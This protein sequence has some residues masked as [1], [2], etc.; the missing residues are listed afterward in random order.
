MA[1]TNKQTAA[2][3]VEHEL[4]E[5]GRR[6]DSMEP[7]SISTVAGKSRLSDASLDQIREYAK[8]FLKSSFDRVNKICNKLDEKDET[9]NDKCDQDSNTTA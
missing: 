2:R 4:T 6:L 5:V 1:L 9:D 8:G 7:K 3:I